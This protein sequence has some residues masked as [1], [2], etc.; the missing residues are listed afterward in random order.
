MFTVHYMTC[1]GK[2]EKMGWIE[3]RDFLLFTFIIAPRANVIQKF[4]LYNHTFNV[5]NPSNI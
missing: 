3:K 4:Y 1:V 5:E 2:E